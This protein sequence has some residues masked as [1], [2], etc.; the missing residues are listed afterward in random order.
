MLTVSAAAL[1]IR[2]SPPRIRGRASGAWST[3]FLL[4]TTA[5]PLAGGAL[6]TTSLRAPFVVYPSLL[7]VAAAVA[8]ACLRGWVPPHASPDCAVAAVRFTSLLRHPTFRAALA[9][10]FLNGGTVYGVRIA[11]VPL[12]VLDGLHA[13]DVSS[14]VT[15]TA[16]ALGTATALQVGGRWSDR[17]G[18]RTPALTGYAVVAATALWLGFSSSVA[19]LVVAALLSGI[20]TGL[21]N[22]V[23]N[24]AVGN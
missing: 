1:V 19:E 6:A 13:S 12:F 4:G 16:F 3:G 14:G 15:L 21:M 10:N 5:G 7:A 18:R 8:L 23:V 2:I 20:G 17:R 9:A 11:L 24:A 22:P